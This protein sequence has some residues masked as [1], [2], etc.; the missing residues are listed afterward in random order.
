MNSRRYVICDIEATGLDADKELIEIALITY[1]DGKIID[2]YETLINPLKP[3][4]EHISR[5]TSISKKQLE[6]APKFYDV[7]ESIRHRLEGAVFVSHNV[8]FDLGLLKKK[9]LELGAPVKLKTFCTLKVA[10]HEI[11]GLT[12]YN[13]DALCSFFGIKIYDRHRAIGDARATLDLFKEL[14]KLRLKTYTKPLYLPQHERQLKDLPNRAGLLI[15]KNS[16]GR[17]VRM[18][19][20]ANLHNF[21]RLLLEIKHENRDLLRKT[22]LIEYELTGSLLI[23]EFRKLLFYPMHA[24]WMIQVQQFDSG[25]KSFKLRPFKK[26]EPGLWYFKDYTEARRKLT[27]LTLNLK[28]TTYAYREGKPSKEEI[29][30]H[31]QKV[32]FMVKRAQF[33]SENLL[34]LGEGRTLGEKSLILIKDGHV[35]GYGYSENS[36]SELTMIP[37]RFLVKRFFKHLGADLAAKSYI[38]VLKNM[39]N[40]TESWQALSPRL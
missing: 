29:I 39:K 26:G 17:T 11:P 21:A 13:L 12:N 23:A 3:L 5:L 35:L 19:A 16:Q 33:P 1:Q 30:G 2:V 6:V 15:L 4:P 34:I 38:R 7:A 20:V 25:E 18:E 22:T 32:D 24:N 40:K 37:E 27:H 9:F 36:V 8:E 31:N 28:K 14:F 10:L